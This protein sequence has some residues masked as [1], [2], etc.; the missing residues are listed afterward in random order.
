MWSLEDSEN[1]LIAGTVSVD[2]NSL[3]FD[4]TDNLSSLDNYTLFLISGIRDQLGNNLSPTQITFQT[5]M[6]G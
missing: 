4:P 5:Q 6:L 3:T 1:N 2:N